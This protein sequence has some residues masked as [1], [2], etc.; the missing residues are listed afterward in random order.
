MSGCP[1]CG[2]DLTPHLQTYLAVTTLAEAR[3]V[4][5]DGIA[6]V[7]SCPA[8]H[9]RCTPDAPLLISVDECELPLF[10]VPANSTTAEE[11]GEQLQALLDVA[12][13]SSDAWQPRWAEYI[14]GARRDEIAGALAVERLQRR[15]VPAGLDEALTALRQAADW[16]VVAAVLKAAP[17]LISDVALQLLDEQVASLNS[18]GR[19]VR[20]RLAD[21]DV[22]EQ[23]L[24]AGIDAV[25]DAHLDREPPELATEFSALQALAKSID[26]GEP[27]V[28]I[29][30]F[31]AA[32]E[33]LLAAPAMAGASVATRRSL[34]RRAAVA[35][36]TIAT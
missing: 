20:D 33:H 19:P 30:G 28:G 4:V 7:V 29:P 23:C 26:A 1:S 25:A 14:R 16:S 21:R 24:A 9:E 34:H 13:A 11:D 6:P 3:A 18:L 27:G 32:A 22:L 10:F 36:R 5:G 35:Y 15:D 17:M 2:H 12:A 8:C 31:I